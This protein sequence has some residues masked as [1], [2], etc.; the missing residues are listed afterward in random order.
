MCNICKKLRLHHHCPRSDGYPQKF[1][2][3]ASGKLTVCLR[4]LPDDAV[5]NTRKRRGERL[6]GQPP[7]RQGPE[8]NPP[9]LAIYPSQR[10]DTVER[11]VR[12]NGR[13]RRGVR[14]RNLFNGWET[15]RDELASVF[16]SSQTPFIRPVIIF[17]TESLRLVLLRECLHS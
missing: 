6:A 2:Q 13:Q 3:D 10:A 5:T 16:Q 9:R 17:W 14:M 1:E 4:E 7:V 15:A 11:M 12:T 8:T